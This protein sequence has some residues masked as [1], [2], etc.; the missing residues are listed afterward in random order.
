VG[1]ERIRRMENP[2]QL[3]ELGVHLGTARSL[4]EALAA[5]TGQD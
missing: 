3:L 5:V 2:D 1:W 4:S